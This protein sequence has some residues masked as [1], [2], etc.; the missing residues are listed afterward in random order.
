MLSSCFS[1]LSTHYPCVRPALDAYE[2]DPNPT[3]AECVVQ[4]IWQNRITTFR[5]AY[6]LCFTLCETQRLYTLFYKLYRRPLVP[7]VLRNQL[8]Q[9]L[10]QRGMAV[11]DHWV[12]ACLQYV[13]WIPSRAR[14]YVVY[15]MVL[16]RT[17]S[18]P[19]K[20][21]CIEYSA[22]EKGIFCDKK[23]LGIE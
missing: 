10:A 12:D 19:P 2:K 16:Y 11:A 20:T 13:Y 5:E 3:N 1:H 8:A 21:C 4:T 9:G 18:M 23:L 17:L 7:R 22:K 6:L 15:P 14:N